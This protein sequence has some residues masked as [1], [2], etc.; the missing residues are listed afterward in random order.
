VGVLVQVILNATAG[1]RQSGQF[2][3]PL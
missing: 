2:Y 1:K 3:R